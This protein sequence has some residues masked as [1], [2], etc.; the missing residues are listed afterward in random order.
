MRAQQRKKKIRGAKNEYGEKK[1]PRPSAATLI[2]SSTD[3]R[4][5]FTPFRERKFSVYLPATEHLSFG[6]I[7][8]KRGKVIKTMHNQ[9]IITRPEC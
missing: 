8:K 1:A 6:A 4:K 2:S 9:N 7:Q 3:E 5:I